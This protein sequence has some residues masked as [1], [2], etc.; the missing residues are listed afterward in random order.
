MEN[1]AILLFSLNSPPRLNP[2]IFKFKNPEILFQSFTRFAVFHAI[3]KINGKA[4]D[5][6]YY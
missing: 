3:A 5:E 2:C 4:D 1:R 6:P